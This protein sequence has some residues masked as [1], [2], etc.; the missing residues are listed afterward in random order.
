[1][2]RSCRLH[3]LKALAGAGSCPHTAE[4]LLLVRAVGSGLRLMVL[5]NVD[6]IDHLETDIVHLFGPPK[7]GFFPRFVGFDL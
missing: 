6:V 4:K 5:V 1:M 2:A 3:P 7:S